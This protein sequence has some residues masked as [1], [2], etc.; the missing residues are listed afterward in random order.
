M[1][2]L[3]NRYTEEETTAIANN[4]S[5][6]I[7]KQE[8]EITSTDNLGDLKLAYP[9]KK[10]S[11]GIY[12]VVEFNAPPEK[13]AVLEGIFKLTPE[14]LRFQIVSK[15]L[16]TQA[17]IE[18]ERRRHERKIEKKEAP[19]TPP[20]KVSLEELDKKLGEILGGEII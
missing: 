11:S 16:K 10:N 14:I 3:P 9:I 1:F 15:K 5:D 2:I 17:D 12:L 7:K 13:I 20:P 8:G 4:V 18:A 6:L 19:K